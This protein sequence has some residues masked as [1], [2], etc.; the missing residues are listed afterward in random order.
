MNDTHIRYDRRCRIRAGIEVCDDTFLNDLLYGIIGGNDCRADSFIVG[1]SIERRHIDTFDLITV[2]KKLCTGDRS[3]S[4][5]R[6]LVFMDLLT[7]LEDHLLAFTHHDDVEEISHRLNVI[8]DRAAA[9]DDRII[10]ATVP[11]KKRDPAKVHHLK[12]IGEA[13][14]VTERET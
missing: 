10:L 6:K 8:R 7:D 4:A 13:H 14:L 1:H 5:F 2:S 3:R 11:G 12:D 9:A